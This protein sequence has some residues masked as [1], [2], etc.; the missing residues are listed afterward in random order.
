MYVA[1]N[2]GATTT[3]T[4]TDKPKVIDGIFTYYDGPKPQVD[5]TSMLWGN[6]KHLITK[7]EP[8]LD[9]RSLPKPLSEYNHDKDGIQILH[10]PDISVLKGNLYDHN[11]VQ[12][13]YRQDLGKFIKEKLGLRYCILWG[14]LVRD[15]PREVHTKVGEKQVAYP[16]ASGTTAF[17][18]AHVDFS[19][20]SSHAFLR[21]AGTPDYFKILNNAYIPKE[22]RVSF[23]T[24][25]GKII[26]AKE[27]AM[28]KASIDPK[29]EK[30][31]QVKR[32]PIAFSLSLDH[33]LKYTGLRRKYHQLSHK[34]I[35]EFYFE[36]MLVH[37]KPRQQWAYISN[38]KPEE[39]LFIK[40]YDTNTLES[41]GNTKSMRVHGAFHVPGTESLPP[42]QSIETKL[43][44]IYKN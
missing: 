22:D 29:A 11:Y 13:H 43:F 19:P 14:H 2:I 28:R 38:Q 8:V 9:L 26:A 36:N 37:P 6:N 3:T 15:V 18:L 40:F 32:D 20:A 35:G 30:D 44:F 31:G 5:D 41:D 21:S 39:I 27:A 23:F 10:K 17:H 34:S 42:R 1:G 4:T 16:T 12:N 33:D 24:L 25:R 7:T